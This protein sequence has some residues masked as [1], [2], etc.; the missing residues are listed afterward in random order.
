MALQNSRRLDPNA[1][2]TLA[3][4][5][6]VSGREV[7]YLEIILTQNS[8]PIRFAGYYHGG[9]KSN[10]QVV[11]YAIADEFEDSRQK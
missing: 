1:R 6:I 7:P 4:R 10:L 3:E 9:V 11:A 2:I 8:I 5:R